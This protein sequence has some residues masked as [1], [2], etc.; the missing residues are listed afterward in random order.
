MTRLVIDATSDAQ[1]ARPGHRWVLE[2]PDDPVFTLG[3]EGRL[4]Q[5]L[6]NLL[7]NAGQHTP[8]EDDGHGPAACGLSCRTGSRGQ[9]PES[10]ARGTVP[11]APQLVLSVTD[12]GGEVPAG[13]VP[14]LFGQ[15]TRADTSRSHATSASSTGLGLAIVDAVVAAHHGAVLVTSWPGC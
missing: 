2:L 14:D 8:D 9:G 13:L 5:V 4:R 7:S 3:D 10:V 6:G 11:P 15:F 1:A 12:D